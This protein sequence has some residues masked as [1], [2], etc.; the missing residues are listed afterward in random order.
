MYRHTI[1]HLTC[2]LDQLL[3][4]TEK[5]LFKDTAT[6]SLKTLIT[7]MERRKSIGEILAVVRVGLGLSFRGFAQI[8]GLSH[9][10]LCKLEKQ[11]V[12]SPTLS[13]LYII[14]DALQISRGRLFWLCSKSDTNEKRSDITI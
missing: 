6:I 11:Q 13:V 5:L 4:E 9:A 14:A 8:I 3:T 7:G 1:I 2:E 10:Y 12:S